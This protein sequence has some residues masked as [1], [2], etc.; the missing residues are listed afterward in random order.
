M[1]TGN[2]N[3]TSKSSP[4]Q[5]LERYGDFYHLPFRGDELIYKG[6]YDVII[7]LVGSTLPIFFFQKL[8][9]LNQFVEKKIER[10][11]SIIFQTK[12]A[13]SFELQVG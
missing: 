13:V 9:R 5:R 4:G 3:L 6:I 2:L 11:N 1:R 12:V 7:T 10:K 8:R